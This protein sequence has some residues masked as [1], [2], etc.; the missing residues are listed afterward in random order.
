MLNGKCAR[1]DEQY[2]EHANPRPYA[3]AITVGFRH[4]A[5]RL[6]SN[7][8]GVRQACLSTASWLLLK[9][10]WDRNAYRLEV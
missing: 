9:H 10:A 7:K 1:R 2:E 5:W 8:R 4:R 6:V 3:S